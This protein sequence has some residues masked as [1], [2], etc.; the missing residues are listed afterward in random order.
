MDMVLLDWTRMGGYYCLAGVTAAQG[1]VGRIANPSYHVVRPLLA[2]M[3]AAAVANVGWSP[4]LLDGHERWEVFELIAPQPAGSPP[5]HVEDCWV[6]SLQPRKRLATLEQRRSIL[7]ATMTQKGEPLFGAPFQ[8]S[9]AAAGL[10]PGTGQRSLVTVLVPANQI[11]FSASWRDGAAEPDFRVTLP[12][13]DLGPRTLPMKDHCLLHRI[14]SVSSDLQQQLL[15]MEQVVKHMGPDVVVRLGLSRPFQS[16]TGGRIGN[17]SYANSGP[18]VCWLMADGFFSF[19]D[20]Q[21]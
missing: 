10:H 16:S 8:M 7:Q 6:R 12:V 5:P 11:A 9:R 14:E 18:G 15:A 13:P 19:T 2:K 21:P 20:P 17:P 3:R 4:Y 1:Q